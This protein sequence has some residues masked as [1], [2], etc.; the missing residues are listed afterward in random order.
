MRIVNELEFMG[1]NSKSAINMINSFRKYQELIQYIVS[2]KEQGRVFHENDTIIY[3]GKMYTVSKVASLINNFANTYN[4]MYVRGLGLP[5][6]VKQGKQYY[7]GSFEEDYLNLGYTYR[8]L[9]YSGSLELE[10]ISLRD[11]KQTVWIAE[12]GLYIR[13]V[14]KIVYEESEL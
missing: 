10:E 13:A 12:N 9:Y 1:E 5:M 3:E 14:N 6:I 4:N 2:E 11:G 7:L 8:D